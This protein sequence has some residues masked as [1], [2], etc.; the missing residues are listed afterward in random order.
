MLTY[1]SVRLSTLQ[2]DRLTEL[3]G[4]EAIQLNLKA[5]P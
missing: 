5:A 4:D 2:N 3:A 1:S